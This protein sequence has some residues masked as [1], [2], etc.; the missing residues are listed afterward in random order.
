MKGGGH[1]GWQVLE[2]FGSVTSMRPSKFSEI[3]GTRETT[4]D[5]RIFHIPHPG[6]SGRTTRPCHRPA[7]FICEPCPSPNNNKDQRLSPVVPEESYH[8]KSRRH[9]AH[10]RSLKNFV[11][12]CGCCVMSCKHHLHA[13][14][15]AN[16][17]VPSTATANSEQMRLALV[18][19]VQRELPSLIVL[20]VLD[21]TFLHDDFCPMRS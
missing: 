15:T 16:P 6:V 3:L 19:V 4:D 9:V 18:I 8:N 12:C 20:R 2:H 10:G 7:H 13:L 5:T 11:T 17:V 14:A 1:I 21:P